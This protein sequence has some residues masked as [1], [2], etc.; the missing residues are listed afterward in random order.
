MKCGGSKNDAVSLTF[1]ENDA[2]SAVGATMFASKPDEI[3]T[4]LDATYA[5]ACVSF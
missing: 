5:S 1:K 2:V 3:H 4:L